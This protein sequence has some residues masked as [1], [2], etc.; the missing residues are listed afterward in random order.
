[1]PRRKRLR[2]RWYRRWME[3]AR[4]IIVDGEDIRKEL[5]G[6]GINPARVRVMYAAIDTSRYHPDVSTEPFWDLLRQQ[7]VERHQGPLLVY[8]GRLLFMN[9]PQDFLEILAQ[10]PEAW[11]VVLG[12][13]PDRQA[14]EA[15]AQKMGNRITFVGEQPEGILA[16]AFRAADLCLF[17]LSASI[18]GIS[19]VVPKAMACGAGVSTNAGAD[20]SHLVVPGQNGLLCSEGNITEWVKATRQLIES[21]DLRHRMSQSAAQTIQ[22]GW[23]EAVREKEYREWFA[24]LVAY[25]VS[26]K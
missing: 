14:L 18:A 6:H 24:S 16:S 7:G 5:A 9:R 15:K 19:L 1:M 10:V 26:R 8:C 13:G 25:S 23:S 11:G 21:R 22:Q 2:N 12:D 20:L 4:G 17:P 3:R